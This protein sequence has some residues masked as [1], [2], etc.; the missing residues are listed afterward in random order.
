MACE[1]VNFECL[2]SIPIQL[3]RCRLEVHIYVLSHSVTLAGRIQSHGAAVGHPHKDPSRLPLPWACGYSGGQ[4]H[5]W[6]QVQPS[7]C[8]TRN[9][10]MHALISPY[11]QAV[12]RSTAM[13]LLRTSRFNRADPQLQITTLNAHVYNICMVHAL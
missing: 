3:K 6:E 7:E 11:A 1:T 2:N 5:A 4:E 9:P 10:L 8:N 12:A 13:V